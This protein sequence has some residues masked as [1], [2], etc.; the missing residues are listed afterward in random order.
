MLKEKSATPDGK[1]QHT[2]YKLF[3]VILISSFFTFSLSADINW[4]TKGSPTLNAE[5]GYSLPMRR[6][7]RNPVPA[8][9]FTVGVDFR[10][11]R[12]F[13]GVKYQGNQFDLTNRVI[14]MPT[15]NNAFQ[16]GCG[17]TWHFYRYF[18]EFTENDLIFNVRFRWFKGPVFSFENAAGFLFKFAAIDAI[19]D[20]KPVIFNFSYNWELLCNWHLFNR[21]DLWTA[22]NLQDFYDYPLAISPIYKLG[23]GYYVTPEAIFGIDFT[24]KFVDMF[25]SAVYMNE[26][27]IRLTFKVVL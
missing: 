27:I 7:L 17:F 1:M 11:L 13:S 21:T 3:L 14:Y 15:L 4:F 5:W 20:F 22:L 8:E 26:S 2:S 16:A 10:E 18:E 9:D 25:F 12:L 23:F 24:M 19:R 6:D